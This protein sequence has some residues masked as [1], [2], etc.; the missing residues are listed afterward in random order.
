ME[1]QVAFRFKTL[2]PVWGQPIKKRS[3]KRR[4]FLTIQLLSTSNVQIWF[5]P[6]RLVHVVAIGTFPAQ[7]GCTPFIGPS[8]CFILFYNINLSSILFA[9]EVLRSLGYHNSKFIMAGDDN[10]PLFVGA[11]PNNTDG[12]YIILVL[13]PLLWYNSL[14]NDII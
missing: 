13:H 4:I 9:W 5:V 3:S 11:Y 2:H 6:R 1:C 8:L 12:H 10:Q 14:F 7:L